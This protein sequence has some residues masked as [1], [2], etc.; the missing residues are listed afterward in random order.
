VVDPGR[1]L[2]LGPTTYEPTTVVLEPGEAL[3]LLSDGIY[4]G[5]APSG[6]MFGIERTMALAGKL[7]V[8]ED[9]P[10]EVLRRLA[11]QAIDFQQG[12]VR[13]DATVAL[14]RYQPEA[15]GQ[16]AAPA[17]SQLEHIA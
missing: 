17:D 16:L 11:R 8:E 3:L 1:P 4:E 7:F 13:D 14:V 12:D 9:R 2:G 6:E 15:I 10:S 5:R